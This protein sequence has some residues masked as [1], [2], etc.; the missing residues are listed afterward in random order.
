MVWQPVIDT[1]KVAPYDCLVADEVW[2]SVGWKGSVGG[3]GLVWQ[4]VVDTSK[5]A[6]YHCLVADDVRC[7]QV[8]SDREVWDRVGRWR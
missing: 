2:I 5:V 1:S 8:W 6:P 4:L 3:K 7:E